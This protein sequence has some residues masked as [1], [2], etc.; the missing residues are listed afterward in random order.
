MLLGMASA[1]ERLD[2]HRTNQP[3]SLTLSATP[4]LA[5]TSYCGRRVRPAGGAYEK[6]SYTRAGAGRLD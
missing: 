6:P 1:H 2:L 4:V 5:W 3:L